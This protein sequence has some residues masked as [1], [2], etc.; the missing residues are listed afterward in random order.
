MARLMGTGAKASQA[1]DESPPDTAVSVGTDGKNRA[2]DI[3][4]TAQSPGTTAVTQNPSTDRMVTTPAEE[5]GQML[6]QRRLIQRQ[7]AIGPTMFGLR[8]PR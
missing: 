3:D 1:S 4:E 7:T 6:T 5:Q 8:P 2:A